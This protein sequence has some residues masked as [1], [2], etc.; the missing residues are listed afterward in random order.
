MQIP[1]VDE[2][3]TSILGSPYCK[4]WIYIIPEALDDTIVLKLLGDDGTIAPFV[5][6]KVTS[7]TRFKDLGSLVGF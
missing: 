6:G 4:Y 5:S 1:Y 2:L 7:V 3:R